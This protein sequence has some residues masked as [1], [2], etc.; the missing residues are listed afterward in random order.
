M[1]GL[2]GH[3]D[4]LLY[5]KNPSLSNNGLSRYGLEFLFENRLLYSACKNHVPWA[6]LIVSCLLRVSSTVLAQASSQPNPRNYC[7]SCFDLSFV[8]LLILADFIH[9]FHSM[10]C[11][12]LMPLLDNFSL[13]SHR[14]CPTKFWYTHPIYCHLDI[15]I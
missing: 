6:C 7:M 3:T 4:D 2:T 8:W 10:C 5:A 11:M 13:F 9:R 1:A 12:K 15:R 14:Y